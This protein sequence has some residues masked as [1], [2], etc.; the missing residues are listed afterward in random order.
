M[1][2]GQVRCRIHCRLAWRQRAVSRA[3]ESRDA[4]LGNLAGKD[5]ETR[6]VGRTMVGS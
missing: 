3:V 5:S 4:N 1:G 2:N 6:D